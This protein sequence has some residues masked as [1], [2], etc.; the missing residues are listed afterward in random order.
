VTLLLSRHLNL[1]GSTRTSAVQVRLDRGHDLTEGV[2]VTLAGDVADVRQQQRV[3]QRAQRA[4][5]RQ[6]LGLEDVQARAGDP[7]GP[8]HLDQRL[9]VDERSSRRVDQVG[10]R[11]HQRQLSRAD[12]MAGGGFGAHVHADHVGRAE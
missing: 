5:R 3:G 2:P 11:L 6:R 9:L 8:Q 7:A 4:V 12:E 1:I 10:R